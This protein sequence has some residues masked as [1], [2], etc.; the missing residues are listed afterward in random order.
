VDTQL[1]DRASFTFTAAA[2]AMTKVINMKAGNKNADNIKSGFSLIEL[3]VALMLVGLFT[4][5]AL[6]KYNLYA[7]TQA[8]GT[9]GAKGG[10]LAVA[11]Q[12]YYLKVGNLPCPAD[13]TLPIT[14]PN[15]GVS[16][17]T[18]GNCTGGGVTVVSNTS[19]TTGTVVKVAEGSIPYTTLSLAGGT[20]GLQWGDTMDGWGR[21]L[22]YWVSVP[23]TVHTA[24]PI[25]E[26]NL[27]LPVNTGVTI[28]GPVPDPANPGGAQTGGGAAG[29]LWNPYVPATA[30]SPAQ[31]QFEYAIFSYGSSGR[32]GYTSAGITPYAPC[33]G[34]GI[35]LLNCPGNPSGAGIGVYYADSATGVSI[36]A[37]NQSSGSFYDDYLLTYQISTA[38]N[39]WDTQNTANTM[40][41][42]M[43]GFVGVNK[44]TPQAPV[45]VGGPILVNPPA[46][47]VTPPLAPVATSA[48]VMAPSY[49][50]LVKNP[51]VAPSTTG[52]TTGNC[53]APS[54][55]AGPTAGVGG[56]NC[57]S[58]TLTG[59]AL[60]NPV[61]CTPQG[62][63]AVVSPPT[64]SFP[65]QNPL[66]C[67]SQ[68]SG[69]PG[70]RYYVTGFSPQGKIQCG[71]F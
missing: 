38:N 15:A 19:P 6:Q 5:S 20:G 39:F 61:P 10:P 33:S 44:Q 43:L 69:P 64:L 2:H 52:S 12:K 11:L 56:L 14:D 17:G 9:T 60:S 49:C 51:P 70:S 67:A 35:D 8:I 41:N 22:A 21:K 54:T 36:R 40:Y 1:H 47:P 7:R 46:P 57:G 50:H 13:P 48:S 4:G 18:P 59:I 24:L 16:M 31:Q 37:F 65:F 66:N 45:D 63:G 23:L 30:I 26:A 42:S 55:L 28:Y 53:F 58:T 27:L 3:S 62:S 25:P 29:L 71:T 34:T 68:G 32:G